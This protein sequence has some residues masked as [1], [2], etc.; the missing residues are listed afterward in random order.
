MLDS[1]QEASWI[2]TIGPSPARDEIGSVGLE[3]VAQA[4]QSLLHGSRRRILHFQRMGCYPSQIQRGHGAQQMIAADGSET[5]PERK[6]V[7]NVHPQVIRHA[8]LILLQT[9]QFP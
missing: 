2:E 9:R 6:I 3:H 7:H 1:F 4:L 5:I 8:E